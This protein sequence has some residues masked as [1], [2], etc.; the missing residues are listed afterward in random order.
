MTDETNKSEYKILLDIIKK[1]QVKNEDYDEIH[2]SIE[3]DDLERFKLLTEKHEVSDPHIERMFDLERK[4]FILFTLG[5]SNAEE[6]YDKEFPIEEYIDIS[7]NMQ[8]FIHDHRIF[9]YYEHENTKYCSKCNDRKS[10]IVQELWDNYDNEYILYI[11]WLPRETC[12]ELQDFVKIDNTG[13]IDW[14]VF[15]SSDEE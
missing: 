15:S 10:R 8:Q 12:K 14:R 6:Y 2:T 3:N 4:N 7:D 1:I 13:H 5:M 11:E 9:T